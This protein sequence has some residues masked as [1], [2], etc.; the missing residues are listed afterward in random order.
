[1]KTEL[2]S[3]ITVARQP[4]SNAWPAVPR[5]TPELYQDSI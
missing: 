4:G 2:K 5:A 3:S 1:M